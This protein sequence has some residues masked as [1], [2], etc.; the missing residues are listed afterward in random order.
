VAPTLGT[1]VLE[2]FDGG[3]AGLMMDD[4]QNHPGDE[5]QLALRGVLMV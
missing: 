1:G 2:N 5:P 4:L 3:E